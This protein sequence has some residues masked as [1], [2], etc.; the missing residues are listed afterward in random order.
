MFVNRYAVNS[1]SCL[2]SKISHSSLRIK[3]R[4]DSETG[5][6]KVLEKCDYDLLKTFLKR[7]PRAVFEESK[8]FISPL[9]YLIGNSLTA[10]L[11]IPVHLEP[12]KKFVKLLIDSGSSVN[13]ENI[14]FDTPIEVAVKVGYLGVVVELLKNQATVR[15]KTL[16]EAFLRKFNVD[17]YFRLEKLLIKAGTSFSQN[18]P[19]LFD[20]L[21]QE[22]V[23]LIHK[24]SVIK[25]N[26]AHDK[27]KIYAENFLFIERKIEFLL[28]NSTAANVPFQNK[29]PLQRCL[30]L[31][32][33]F[34]S[35][36]LQDYVLRKFIPQIIKYTTDFKVVDEN[37]W[38]LLHY[39]AF[40]GNQELV[41][42]LLKKGLDPYKVDKKGFSPVDLAFLNFETKLVDL[43]ILPI[44]G[45]FIVDII[46]NLPEKFKPLAPYW[47]PQEQMTV[48]STKKLFCYSLFSPKNLFR[49]N[50]F[51]VQ[52]KMMYH[53]INKRTPMAIAI[54]EQ[55]LDT[56]IKLIDKGW[57]IG[58]ELQMMNY[59]RFSNHQ[60]ILGFYD[61]SLEIKDMKFYG[62]LI[63][64]LHKSHFSGITYAS[65]F[66]SSCQK[67][68]KEKIFI[69]FE[70][71]YRPSDFTLD[72]K[73]LDFDQFLWWWY[74]NHF[75]DHAGWHKKNPKS[76]H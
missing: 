67:L 3:K 5:I 7:N 65:E 53:P 48:F 54:Q 43:E 62:K 14:N 49:K 40:V 70:K 20:I 19:E 69:L 74:S 29:T 31:L 27:N 46:A 36:R 39:A 34:S 42:F 61:A 41:D 16:K 25:E 10:E 6:F 8:S 47:L 56:I 32:D 66:E 76:L 37:G 59:Q 58:L 52:F 1:L 2:T 38:S 44:D 11:R 35:E 18:G 73:E 71:G 28:K 17:P 63:D 75:C 9:H 50:P 12:P 15:E 64:I 68:N 45:N 51:L 26:I 30:E 57:N 55:N 13:N 23:S 24:L 72:S 21:I 33:P 4:M 60:K 22:T